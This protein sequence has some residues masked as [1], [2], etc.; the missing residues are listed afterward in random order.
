MHFLLIVDLLLLAALTARLVRLLI[1]D[2]IGIWFVQ[3]P[4]GDWVSEKVIAGS[5]RANLYMKLYRGLSCPYCIGFWI[6]VAA[7][8]SLAAVGGPGAG[9]SAIIVWRYVA[10]AFALNYVVSHISSRLGDFGADD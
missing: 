7:L 8:T 5:R 3:E 10:G 2:D 9:G 1:T 4:L 6:G